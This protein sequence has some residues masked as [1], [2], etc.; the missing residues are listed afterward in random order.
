MTA[1]L[2][3]PYRDGCGEDPLP[4]EDPIPLEGV[5]PVLEPD[6]HELREPVDLLSPLEDGVLERGRLQEPLGDLEELDGRVASPADG[7]LLGVV[8][9]L[10]EDTGGAE[11]LDGGLPGLEDGH[12]GV[13]SGELGHPSGLVDSLLHLE[14]VLHDPL[15]IVLVTDG[16]D[17]HVSG[18]VVQLDLGI[19]DDL[20]PPSEQGGDEL[21]ADQMGLLLVVGVD[22]DRLTGA[23]EL[24]PGGGDE[25]VVVGIGVG[26]LELDVVELVDV[27]PVLDLRIREGGHTSGTPVDGEVRLVDESPVEQV[28]EGELGDPPVVGG[29][30][31]V[32]DAG[33]HGLSE[34]LEVLGHL[35]DEAVGVLLAESPVLLPGGVQLRDVV[36]LLDLDLDG[37]T[38]DIEAQGEEHVVAAHP[39]ETGGEVDQGVSGGVS[40]VEGTGCVPGGIVD[41]VHRLVGVGVE[42]VDRIVPP[43]LLPA[44]L[45]GR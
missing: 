34:H 21:L 18:S 45:Y 42:A 27:V 40:E 28:D 14:V 6:L 33:V 26:D 36:L 4:A 35:L 39:P 15:E 16:A 13:L 8:L 23:Q 1:V 3:L 24:G 17:H 37:G 22:G 10:D 29:I 20:D 19:G 31:L 11:V 41:A 9:L 7:D 25:H 12:S 43:H 32:V 44:F 30:R 2:A 5:G 38:V